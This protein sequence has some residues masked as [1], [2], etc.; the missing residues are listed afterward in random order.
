MR[1]GVHFLVDF[2]GFFWLLVKYFL[3]LSTGHWSR[4]IE[5]C[6]ILTKKKII[7][8][9]LKIEIYSQII[10][11]VTFRLYFEFYSNLAYLV[12]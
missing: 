11:T 9:N 5:I 6:F 10:D 1:D 3:L 12:W 2:W 4:E 8:N 7:K